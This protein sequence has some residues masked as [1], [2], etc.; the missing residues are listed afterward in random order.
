MQK[1]NNSTQERFVNEPS[2]IAR[3]EGRQWWL[4]FYAVAVT[5]ALTVGLVSFAATGTSW[6]QSSGDWSELRDWVRA[7]AALVLLFDLY[8]MYQQLQLYRIRRVMADQHRLFRLISEHA[9]DMIS[10]VSADGKALYNSP[11]FERVLGYPGQELNGQS[12]LQQVHPEDKERVSDAVQQ[13]LH[14]GHAYPLEYRIQ[15]KNG[16]WR[17]L[18]STANA[19]RDPEDQS[20]NLV[21]VNRDITERKRVEDLLE[22]NSL[23]D[24]LTNLPNRAF[25]LRKLERVF[26]LARRHKDYNFAVLFVD[27]DDFKVVNDSLGHAAGDEL[28]ILVS[29]RLATCIRGLELPVPFAVQERRGYSVNEDVLAR[30]SGDQF[31]ILLDDIRDPRD[32]MRVCDRIQQKLGSAFVIEGQHVVVTASLGIALESRARTVASDM[33]RDAEIAAHRAKS[34]GKARSETFDPGMHASALNR[35]RLEAELRKGLELGEVKAVF[36]PIISLQSGRI[37]GFEALSR[38]HKP[39]RVV[40]PAE[41]IDIAEDTGLILPLTRTIIQESCLRLR[42]WQEKFSPH[43]PFRMSVNVSRKQFAQPGFPDE[44]SEILKRTGVRPS[45]LNLEIVETIA[46]DDEE[47]GQGVLRKLKSL[48]V[49]LSIDDFGTGYSSLG[50]L[51]RLPVDILKIDRIFVANMETDVGSREIVR[52]IITLAH[53]IGLAV[54]AEGVETESQAN[55]LKALGCEMA[56]GYYYSKP[57]DHEAVEALLSATEPV[58]RSIAAS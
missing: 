58:R 23:H 45:L 17:I 39:D 11:A 38:W 54:V 30:L 15:H 32:A 56:Q 12:L 50:R 52:V 7:L 2:K 4:W 14:T 41:F 18:E 51:Q 3:L 1:L 20:L 53:S 37:V 26:G 25:F 29:R 43:V 22:H 48:G 24:Q 44:L 55:E 33:L 6:L 9:A 16:S 40:M 34:A 36:Q 8:S 47:T 49:M 5:V 46:M 31:A 19:V 28:L 57:V 27:I 35:L 42:S 21:I 13:A 10:L